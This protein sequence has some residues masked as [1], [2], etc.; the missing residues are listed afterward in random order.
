MTSTLTR[1]QSETVRK[2]IRSL[3][4]TLKRKRKESSGTPR[5]PDVRDIFPAQI[6]RISEETEKGRS[7]GPASN[8]NNYVLLETISKEGI[9]KLCIEEKDGRGNVFVTEKETGHRSDEY[10]PRRLPEV[11]TTMFYTPELESKLGLQRPPG[12]RKSR[13]EG[14]CKILETQEFERTKLDKT[15]SEGSPIRSLAGEETRKSVKYLM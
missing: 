14:V 3:N 10:S 11:I 15:K 9:D 13:S 12:I 2:R 6:H 5:R 4:E 1:R 8:N 7:A